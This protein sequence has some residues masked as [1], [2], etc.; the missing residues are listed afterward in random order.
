MKKLLLL[1][2]FV[3]FGA[4]QVSGQFWLDISGKAGYGPNLLIN[5]NILN[6]GDLKHDFASFGLYYAGKFG[7]NFGDEH[8]LNFEVGQSDFQQKWTDRTGAELLERP[9]LVTL[10]F[11]VL[12]RKINLG[13]YIE[14][15]P[16]YSRVTEK[17]VGT[18]Y[19]NQDNFGAILGLGGTLAG[20]DRFALNLGVRFRYV[21]T[22][23]INEAGQAIHYP[24]LTESVAQ[25]TEYTPSTPLSALL[26]LEF[27]WAIGVFGTATCYQGRK[28]F[29]MF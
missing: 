3:L 11:A 25:F 22:D 19:L 7:L 14:L 20:S 15:G 21:F 10:D 28:R 8:S 16:I 5:N 2:A 1:F 4:L 26:M 12:Y 23:V 27:D 17:S 9:R 6:D 29:V 24:A 18:E 13:R